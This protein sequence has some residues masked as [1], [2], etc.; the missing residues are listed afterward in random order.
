MKISY[1]IPVCNEHKELER[2]LEFLTSKKRN[3]D[4]IVVQYDE[5][6]TTPE[7]FKVIGKFENQIRVCNFRLNNDFASFKNNLKNNCSNEWIFQIDADEMPSEHM[8]EILL[9][10]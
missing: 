5:G 8:M 10:F 4:E 1:A 9:H 2:L 7:V 3:Q 6:N